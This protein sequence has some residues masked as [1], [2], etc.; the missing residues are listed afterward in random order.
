MLQQQDR[1]KGLYVL[2]GNSGKYDSPL[3]FLQMNHL[4]M[5]SQ[6][7]IDFVEVPQNLF[8]FEPEQDYVTEY[9]TPTDLIKF[10]PVHVIEELSNI[11]DKCLFVKKQKETN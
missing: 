3:P 10:I 1:K 7:Y 8:S 4:Q 11:I 9:T 6:E 2:E 5:K